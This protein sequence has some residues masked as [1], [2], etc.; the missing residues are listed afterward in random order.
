MILSIPNQLVISVNR[1][2]LGYVDGKSAHSDVADAL[3]TALKPLGDVQ[4]FCPNPHNYLYLIASTKGIIFALALGM[5]TIGVRLDERMKPRALA[6]GGAPYPDCGNEWVSFTL[7]R[8]DWP[9]VDLK[10]WARKAYVAARE[11]EV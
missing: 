7:F 10:F 2:V 4:L 3:I 1:Q 11:V 6:S 8:D 5:N 9:E